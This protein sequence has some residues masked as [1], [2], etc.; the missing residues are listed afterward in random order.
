MEN[1]VFEYLDDLKEF[2]VKELAPALSELK[3]IG[4]DNSRK[5]LQR[6]VYTNLVDRFDSAVDKTLLS[7]VERPPLTD[8]LLN[9]LNSNI[10]EGAVLR[11]L[12][13]G[14]EEKQKATDK[15]RN[16]AREEYLRGRHSSKLDKLLVTIGQKSQPRTPRVNRGTGRIMGSAKFDKKTPLSVT[17]YA[18]WLYSRRNAIVHGA[19][20]NKLYPQDIRYIQDMFGCQPSKTIKIKLSTIENVSHFYSD[21]VSIIKGEKA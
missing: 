8:E 16:L 18:D 10:S 19:G 12:Y 20:D 2:I 4:D 11:M 5:H 14:A 15:L 3:K 17:G 9:K 1:N 13:F 21:V 6:L 7:L